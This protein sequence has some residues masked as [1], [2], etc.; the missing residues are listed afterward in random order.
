MILSAKE[1]IFGEFKVCCLLFYCTCLNTVYCFGKFCYYEKN[2]EDGT[3]I[4]SN[5]FQ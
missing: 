5:A 1:E 2:V 3:T 4:S